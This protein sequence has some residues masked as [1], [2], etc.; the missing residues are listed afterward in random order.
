MQVFAR[1]P[2]GETLVLG[3]D[4]FDTV[5]E[6][7][8]QCGCD[9]VLVTFGGRSLEDGE[10]V[11]LCGMHEGSTLHLVPLLA[12]GGD[13]TPAMGKRHKK[14]HGLCIRC[15][16]RSFHLQKKKCAACGYPSRYIRHYNWS[17]KAK[18]RKA[19]GTGRMRYVKHVHRRFKNGFREGGT[20]PASK[21]AS[22]SD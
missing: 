3:V 10:Q 5:A 16:K 15:G 19:P 2:G 9:S 22:K 6:L 8:E 13:G 14:T 18:R 11:G 7:K 20:P 1:K 21:K 17:K 4:T 12:G